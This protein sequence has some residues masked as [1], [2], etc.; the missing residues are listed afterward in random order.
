MKK[1]ERKPKNRGQFRKGKDPRRHKFTTQECQ[2]GYQN[3][4]ANM[5]DD[6]PDWVCQ[7]GAHYSHCLLRVKNPLWFECRKMEKQVAKLTQKLGAKSE[8]LR[9]IKASLRKLRKE[10]GYS[11]AITK[12]RKEVQRDAKAYIN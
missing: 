4:M 1:T 12:P 6:H 10:S 8:S 7:H 5:L 2:R 11:P 3:A 9:K